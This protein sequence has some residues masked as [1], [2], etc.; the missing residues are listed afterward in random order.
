MHRAIDRAVASWHL[1]R[2]DSVGDGGTTP[3]PSLPVGTDRLPQIRHI[4]LLMMENHS[5]DNY[6]GTL[7]HGD[8][9][10]TGV[11]GQPISANSRTD[12]ATVR[13]YPF[14]ST[15]QQ[16]EDPTPNWKASHIQYGDGTN[17]GFV[18]SI[19][20]LMPERDPTVP[21]GY[22]S[23]AKL[24]F[25]AGLAR[26]FALADHWF[27]SCLGPTFP[28]RRFLISAT[29]HGLIDDIPTGI[30]DYPKGGTIF[31][32][33]DRYGISWTNYHHVTPWRVLAQRLLG[34]GGLRGMRS[35][36]L[37]LGSIF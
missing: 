1:R 28:N 2:R 12:G 10:P 35:L 11:D 3:D 27:C 33:L 29:A 4:V 21:M 6:L 18:R 32:L 5:F 30:I 19:E 31:D 37:A 16:P 36:K 13:V 25:Y 8:G 15:K 26:T 17:N 9:F 7:G 23:K 24:P 22:W 34:G 20:Q 14:P